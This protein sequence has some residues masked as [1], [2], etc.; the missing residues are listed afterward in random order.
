VRSAVT[1]VERTIALTKRTTPGASK[2]AGGTGLD[3][4]IEAANMATIDSSSAPSNAARKSTDTAAKLKKKD[5]R[6]P[7]ADNNIANEDEMFA[8]KAAPPLHKQGRDDEF[9]YERQKNAADRTGASRTVPPSSGPA[10]RSAPGAVGLSY[11]KMQM[12]RQKKEEIEK[13]YRQDCETFATVTKMLISKEPSLEEKIQNSLRENLKDIGH[14]CIQELRDFIE[15]LKE[16]DI[17]D[18]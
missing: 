5:R 2:S 17:D 10:K 4:A 3:D 12:V 16:E 7:A 13:A 18:I 9:V 6:P 8:E 11:E 1:T 14:R 15:R